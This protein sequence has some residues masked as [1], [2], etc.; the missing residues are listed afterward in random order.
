MTNHLKAIV[1]GVLF[2]VI[3]TIVMQLLF[4]LIAVGY[5]YIAKDLPFLKDISWVFR[6]LLGIPVFILIMFIG[7]YI[8]SS[9][10]SSKSILDLMVVGIIAVISMMF[11][12]LVRADITMTGI[13]ISVAM[14]VAVLLGGL[15]ACKRKNY[16]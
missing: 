9:V 14:V 12:L 11:P 2:I 16:H 7:G 4:I 8:T 6:Y 5:N 15:Y 1:S 13:I 3:S 10:L